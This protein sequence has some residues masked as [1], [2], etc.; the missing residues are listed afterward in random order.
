MRVGIDLDGVCYDFAAMYFEWLVIAYGADRETLRKPSGYYLDLPKYD[1]YKTCQESV[2]AGFLYRHGEPMQGTVAAIQ[3][4]KA[5]GHSIHI[6]TARTVEQFGA[7][8]ELNT[9]HWLAQNEIPWDTVTF[10]HDK[11]VVEVDIFVDD[12]IE[13]VDA[14][15]AA[16][17]EAWLKYDPPRTDQLDHPR[18]IRTWDEFLQKVEEL[19]GTL[20]KA[21]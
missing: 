5:D 16:G 13:N 21:A 1:F 12:K 14:L 18:F 2:A 3:K 11:T 8:T 9:Y 17:T 20:K 15:L 6:V 4:L 10:D 19:D 7:M